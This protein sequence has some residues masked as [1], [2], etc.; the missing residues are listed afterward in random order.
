MDRFFYRVEYVKMLHFLGTVF[1]RHIYIYM[2]IFQKLINP[3][4][5][6]LITTS[7][8]ELVKRRPTILL[9]LKGIAVFQHK[10][11]SN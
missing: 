4:R 7:L 11:R 1:L 9:R 2:Y 10:S 8:P 6:T 3:A 5:K